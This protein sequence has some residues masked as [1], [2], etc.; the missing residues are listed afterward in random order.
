MQLDRPASLLTCLAELSSFSRIVFPCTYAYNWF[1]YIQCS[2][3][4]KLCSSRSPA[5]V[6][7][8]LH[9]QTSSAHFNHHYLSWFLL[10]FE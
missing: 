7:V 4:K 5:Q 9:T 6:G 2:E 3:N 8:L 10:V 1:G